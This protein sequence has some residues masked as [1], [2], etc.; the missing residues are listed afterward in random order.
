MIGPNGAGKTTLLSALMGVL[1]SEGEIIF[2]GRHHPHALIEDR[3][4]AGMNLVPEKRE[5]SP[6]CR[7]RTTCC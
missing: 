1:P 2:C 5:F 7:W 6:K 4:A 3:V